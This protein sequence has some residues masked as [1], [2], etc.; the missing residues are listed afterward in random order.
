MKPQDRSPSL[1]T[2]C[3]VGGEEA[4][5]GPDPGDDINWAP[6]VPSHLFLFAHSASRQLRGAG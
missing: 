3:G 5:S 6:V 4:Q 1:L 2:L